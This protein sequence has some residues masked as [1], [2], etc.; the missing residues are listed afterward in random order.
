MKKSMKGV[1]KWI[2]ILTTVCILAGLLSAVCITGYASEGVIYE[3]DFNNASFDNSASTAG[4]LKVN[5]ASGFEGKQKDPE[6]GTSFYYNGSTTSILYT[7]YEGQLINATSGIV[8]FSFEV[9][10]ESFGS[11]SKG[12]LYVRTWTET[13]ITD[14]YKQDSSGTYRALGIFAAGARVYP[15]FP[16]W[17]YTILGDGIELGKWYRVDLVIDLDANTITHYLNGVK[18]SASYTYDGDLYGFSMNGSGMQCYVDN[19]SVEYIDT[20]FTADAADISADGPLNVKFSDTI[21]DY[22]STVENNIAG[23][24]IQK[25]GDFSETAVSAVSAEG[26]R[27]LK[28]SFNSPLDEGCEYRLVLPEGIKDIY[29]NPVARSEVYFCTES[30]TKTETNQILNLDFTDATTEQFATGTYHSLKIVNQTNVEAAQYGDDTEHGNSF[31]FNNK[32]YLYTNS[33][34]GSGQLLN[35]SSGIIDISFDALFTVTAP[36]LTFYVYGDESMA[37]NGDSY[38]K[39]KTTDGTFNILRATSSSGISYF[40]TGSDNDSWKQTYITN[41]ISANEWYKIKVQIDLDTKTVIRTINDTVV[42]ASE[43]PFDAIYGFAFKNDGTE[44]VEYLDN[45]CITH[46]KSYVSPNVK[47][48]RFEN[49]NGE[50]VYP[51][52]SISPDSRK[53]SVAFNTAMNADTLAENIGIRKGSEAVQISSGSYNADTDEYVIEL[54]ELLDENSSYTLTVT[55]SAKSAKGDAMESAWEYSFQTGE[56]RVGVTDFKLTKNS[57]DFNI[58]DIAANDTVTLS[59]TVSNS[60]GSEKDLYIIA[61][62]YNNSYMTGIEFAPVALSAK[63][64]PTPVSVNIIVENADNLKIAGYLWNNFSEMKPYKESINK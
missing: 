35:A 8:D 59:A 48:I 14:H 64:L 45:I 6:H 63:Q 38:K 34:T 3:M 30:T 12:G 20:G 39:H 43:Y 24:K 25:I 44:L 7:Q 21:A 52:Q 40:K 49:C 29:G 22:E 5:G 15:N 4:N 60:T 13:G 37:G 51:S 1:K 10:A 54:T 56:G 27:N 18:S 58:G 46:T 11:E 57:L 36:N 31:K 19:I 9:N 16:A 23:F 17:D 62:V 33:G 50:T 53:I 47:R 61:A 42:D 41:S 55:N 26:G 2:S 32:A 28:V